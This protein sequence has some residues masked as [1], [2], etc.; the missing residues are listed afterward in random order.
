N[1]IEEENVEYEDDL[2]QFLRSS[3]QLVTFELAV[4]ALLL[5]ALTG[6]GRL[7]NRLPKVLD[8]LMETSIQEL[9][10]SGQKF[11][12]EMMG[13]VIE[14]MQRL[15]LRKLSLEDCNMSRENLAPL[16]HSLESKRESLECLNVSD[17]DIDD[18][19]VKAL[20][21]LIKKCTMLRSID[22]RG[23]RLS[24]EALGFLKDAMFINRSVVDL[25]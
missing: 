15:P 10:L 2:A 8:G 13:K 24:D 23:S 7:D 16:A 22:F 11:N 3:P 6:Y 17:N 5:S 18:S 19:V 21:E 12:D 1:V 9:N 25:K 4:L 20:S 14:T